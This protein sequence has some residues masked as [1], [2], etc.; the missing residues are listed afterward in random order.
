MVDTY[1]LFRILDPWLR[2]AFVPALTDNVRIILSGL[3][4]P[5]TGWPSELGGLFRGLAIE[6][7]S[8]ADAGALL[9]RAGVDQANADWIYRFTHGHPLSLRLAASALADR[10]G[11]S[12]EAVTVQALVEEL[13]ELYL[14]VL[15]ARTRAAVS[16]T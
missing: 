3:E 2:Q 4:S 14:G 15:D 5:M 10:P 13:T 11:I 12:L 16:Y 8:R 6:N 7:L 9:G 1:E